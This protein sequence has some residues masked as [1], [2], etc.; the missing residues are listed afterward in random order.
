MGGQLGE[1]IEGFQT[2]EFL[3]E[4]GLIDSIIDRTEMKARITEYLDY[5]CLNLKKG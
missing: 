3:M 5:L 2:A 4:R 1:L